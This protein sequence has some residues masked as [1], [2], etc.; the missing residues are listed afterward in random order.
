MEETKTAGGEPRPEAVVR[1]A[2]VV[3]PASP[4]AGWEV[5]LP[6][7]TLL[8]GGSALELAALVRAVRG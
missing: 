7:G 5:R 2:E 4:A 6:D 3:M 8:R 1:F